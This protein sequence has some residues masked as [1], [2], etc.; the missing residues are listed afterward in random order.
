M[1][2][3][4]AG[5]WI[6]SGPEIRSDTKVICRVDIKYGSNEESEGRANARLIAAAPELLK[7]L[8]NLWTEITCQ[9]DNE[10]SNLLESTLKIMNDA[11]DVIA[12][13][14]GHR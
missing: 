5:P 4:T 1:I 3:H 7:A 13:A 10:G 14:E 12:K 2:N 9:Q 11:R 8:I 6:V